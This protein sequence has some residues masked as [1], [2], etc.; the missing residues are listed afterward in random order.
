MSLTC[1]NIP[2]LRIPW[3]AKRRRSSNT[4]AAATSLRGPVCSS[5]RWRG[6]LS[7]ARGARNPENLRPLRNRHGKPR[8]AGGAD[9]GAGWSG[10]MTAGG[11]TSAGA[12]QTARHMPVLL[13]QAMQMLA[14]RAGGVYVD[15]TFGAGGYSRAILEVAGTQVIG[16]DRDRTAIAAGFDLVDRSDGRLVLVEDRFSELAEVCRQSG[17]RRGGRRRHGHRR[18]VDAARPGRARLLVPSRRP[19]RHAHGPRRA[20]RRRPGRRGVARRSCAHHRRA[21]R[22]EIRAG[23]SRAPSRRRARTRR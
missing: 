19:A 15:A 12:G 10:D 7:T 8:A 17:T 14:P 9:F 21:R 2:R 1:R 6:R 23:R 20:E 22:G 3:R 18:V 13:A 5:D 11:G 16:I 4:M